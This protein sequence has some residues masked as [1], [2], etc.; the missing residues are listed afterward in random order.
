MTTPLFTIFKFLA[1]K[2]TVHAKIDSVLIKSF[3]QSVSLL[4]VMCISV[5]LSFRIK[6]QSL[7]F[8]LTKLFQ[9]IRSS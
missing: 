4:K 8:T 9:E 1:A 7:S 3:L 5:G 2:W 6:E